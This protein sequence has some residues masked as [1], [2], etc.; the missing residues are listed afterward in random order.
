MVGSL[1][2]VALIALLLAPFGA[3]AA[4]LHTGDLVVVMNKAVTKYDPATLEGVQI[5]SGQY[6]Q[7]PRDVAVD[8]RPRILVADFTAGI[9]EIDPATGSQTVLV[10]ASQLGGDY[11]SRICVGPDGR[12]Y[13][14]ATGSSPC[15][16]S[17]A[18]GEEASVLVSSGGLLHSPHGL[19][20]GQDGMLYVCEAGTPV[21]SSC[22]YHNP[23]PH[24]SI[25]RVEPGSGTQTRIATSCDF[26]D[27]FDIAAA[28]PDELWTTQGGEVAGRCGCILSTRISSGVTSE[29][30]PGD[31][32]RSQA[33]A[34]APDG[35][36]W[37]SD[38]RTIGPDCW[39]LY[40]EQWPSGAKMAGVAG[41]MAVV[42]DLPVPVKQT[43]WGKVK[44]NYR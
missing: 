33:V 24:G 25:V 27:P 36:I 18:P 34:A 15:V 1:A 40:T 22:S 21:N 28:G 41:P 31:Y 42:P 19:T 3:S 32:C 8:T 29:A 16:M 37:F 30:V 17:V 12:V 9:I 11:A 38:C 43:T 4:A 35:S 6:L 26:F 23:S 14:S 5:T 2:A 39:Y 10:S 20:F 7:Q 13:F 44:T